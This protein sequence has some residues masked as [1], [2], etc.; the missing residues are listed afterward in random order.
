MEVD[1]PRIL[2]AMTI[3]SILAI[4]CSGDGP[5]AVPL[6]E[7]G[8]RAESSLPIEA[9]YAVSA[10]I[11][12]DDSRYHAVNTA[13]GV[14]LENPAQGVRLVLGRD[15]ATLEADAFVWQMGLVSWGYGNASV[16]VERGRPVTSGNRVELNHGNVTEWYVNGPFGLQ[17]GFTIAAAPTERDGTLLVLRLAAP[18]GWVARL[19]PDG[20]GLAWCGPE[21]A[22]LLSYTGLI[23]VDA[24]GETRPAWLESRDGTLLVCVD[25]AGATYPLTVD[26]WIQDA[27]LTAFDGAAGDRFGYSVAISGD[28]V[29]I[30]AYGD[31]GYKGS[32]YVFV[33]PGSGWA[34]ATETAKL[35]ASDGEASNRFAWSVAISGDTVVIGAYCDDSWRGSAYV[36]EKGAGWASGS[37]NQTAKLTA[38]DGGFT[39][40]FGYSV[41]ISGGTVVVGAGGD[42]SFKG[43]AYVFEKGA[44]W[45]SG[46][47]NQT[48]KLTAFDGAAADEF[49]GSVAISGSTAVVGARGDDS[50]EGSAYVFVEP[51][52]GWATATETAKLTA[53]DGAAPD[54]FGTSVAIDGDTVVVGAGNDDSGKGSAYVFVEPGGGWATATETAKLTAADGAAPDQFGTSVAIDGDT[55]VV[56]AGNDDSG[57]GSAYVFVEPGSGW[58]NMTETAKLTASDGVAE[59][60]FGTS[61]AIDGSTAVVGARGDDGHKGSAYVFTG[62]AISVVPTSGLITTEAGGTATFE[63]SAC[64]AP[65]APVAIPLSS[66]DPSEGAVPAWVVLPW[67]STDPVT[68][69]VTGVDDDVEDGDKLYSIVAGDPSS[70]DPDYDALG[71]GHVDDVSVTNQDDEPPGTDTAATFRVDSTG[72]VFADGTVH[73][74]AFA[75]GAADVAEWVRAS[76]PVTPGDVLVLDPEHRQQ[77]CLSTGPCSLLVAGVVSTEPGVVLG[78]SATFDQR[79]LLALAGIVSVKVTD[80]G[81]PILPGD[82]LVSSSTPGHAMRWAGGDRC[83]CALVGKALEPMIADTGL[84]LVL[85]TAH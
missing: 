31:D 78:A 19:D 73:G 58:A 67:D 47:A 72:G 50:D 84:I 61:V 81:G 32:A 48:A 75:A 18:E 82:L 65:S 28:T 2:A 11:G 68:V 16:P 43:S 35:T 52:G 8:E 5:S 36:F 25:G 24:S 13:T 64:P 38:S 37:A 60:Y 74:A 53:T 22:A 34:T 46:S 44:G 59:D 42:D 45:A 55:V 23:A 71:P 3:L 29:V 85:L 41:A 77:Y 66:S 10:A 17:Q 63:I 57:K 15:G 4:S 1:M 30:G 12:R 69:T 20:R 83:P 6:S 40:G 26:P 56:G 70:A 49:G 9:Q 80:E 54:Q 33:K 79:A 62:P 51:D 39:D 27:K 76:E 21:G 7:D 14:E